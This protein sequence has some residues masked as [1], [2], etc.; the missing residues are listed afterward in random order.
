[1]GKVTGFLEYKREV[2]AQFEVD[3]RIL[4][5]NEIYKPFSKRKT[6]MQAARCM[7]CGVPFCHN[8]CPLG[9]NIPDFNDMVYKQNWEDAY[10]I[11]ISTNNFPEFTGKIC[12][13]PCEESCVLSI[14]KEPTTIKNIEIAIIDQAFANGYVTANEQF[15]KTGYKVAIVGSGPAGLAAAAQ[16]NLAGHDVTVFERD[17]KIG[18]LLRYG[19]PDFKLEKHIIDRRLDIMA[20]S[21]VVFKPNTNVGK[22]ISVK[23]LI[24]TFNAV[25]LAGGSTI[26]RD[27]EAIG[28]EA[29]GVYFAMDFLKQ[30]N[31]RNSEIKIKEED[32]SAKN[33]KVLVIGGGD[34]GSDCVGTSIRQGAKSVL[35]IELLPQP[36]EKYNPATP[37]PNWRNILRTSSS[38][39]EGCDRKW[40]VLT[41]EFIKNEKGELKA[42]SLVDILWENKAGKW[43]FTEIKDSEQ[44]IECDIAFLAVGFL[45]PQK[46]G[47][48][49]ELNVEF[50]NK[51]NVQATNYKTTVD[52]VFTA[53]DM[54]TGQSLVVRAISEGREAA[55]HIDIFLTGDSVLESKT[56]SLNNIK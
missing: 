23:D 15:F 11:L 33:K 29:K 53:G 4:N 21:G 51:A 6:E 46:S 38:H 25:L 42:V 8:G 27:V 49:D 30:Q 17:D 5:Y 40:S 52:K 20:K 3:K 28:R 32:I 56:H 18:G 16:L 54:H 1:M 45:G 2:P 47:L 12:P 19:I 31:K 37:W 22:D 41:K 55:F 50:D 43:S 48:L 39:K 24:N 36:P 9:N 35:Q 13:A 7:D 44:I 14:N 34:T 26:P 10:K